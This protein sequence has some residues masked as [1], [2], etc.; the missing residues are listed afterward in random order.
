MDFSLANLTHAN[1]ARANP[2][3]AFSYPRT[4]AYPNYVWYFLGSFIALISLCHFGISFVTWV[5]SKSRAVPTVSTRGPTS[6]SRIPVALLNVVRNV[7]FRT[8]VS[9]GGSY[10]LNLTEFFLGCAYIATLFTWTLINTTNLEGVRLSPQYYANRTGVIAATQFPF[11]IALGMKN[12]ILTFLT[13]ISFDKLNILHRIAA[14][15]L[16]VMLWIH[17]AGHRQK[18][19]YR[20]LAGDVVSMWN[21]GY[22]C[23]HS[24]VSVSVRPLR[25][26]ATNSSS[27][28]TFLLHSSSSA[29]FYHANSNGLGYFIWPSLMVW[30]LDRFLRFVRIFFVNG[31][32]LTLF[33]T[34]TSPTSAPR[35]KR[36]DHFKWS[37]GQLV[38]LSIPSVSARPW[39]A[40]PFTIASID[41]DIPRAIESQGLSREDSP[42][43]KADS[44]ESVAVPDCPSPPGYSKKLV[45]LLRVHTG[46]TQRLLHAASSPST[47]TRTFNTY[48]DGPYCSPPSGRGFGTVLLFCGGSGISFILPLFLD[49]IKAANTASNPTCRRVVMIWAI[50]HPEQIKA[51]SDDLLRALDGVSDSLSIDIRIHI[52]ASVSAFVHGQDSASDH[53]AEKSEGS[54]SST[55]DAATNL[56][57]LEA[58]QVIISSGRPNVRAII[59]SEI[60]EASSSMSVN[61]CGTVSLAEHVRSALRAT[62]TA[63]DILKGGPSVALHVEVF[64]M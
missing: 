3:R 46:F 35:S 31:G 1:A 26:R 21:N 2:D 22:L 27:S 32:Y 36:P 42:C 7:V 39:E 49:V 24:A 9:F 40:H 18:R 20:R 50:R 17:G 13:G 62:S 14:R 64:G 33:N 37:P 8:T 60:A 16:C 28:L 6:L 23:F 38:Y 55:S 34:K 61:V 56:K 47:P 4:Y 41:G 48:V 52:T 25:S 15:V 43:E 19:K 12:N 11:L 51:I 57:L 30:G 10:T 29:G 53:D 45:F 63:G 54:V 58:S 44:V 59:A 5:R